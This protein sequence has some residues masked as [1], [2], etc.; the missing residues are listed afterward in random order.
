MTNETTAIAEK[1]R[2][3]ASIEASVLFSQRK[4]INEAADELSRLAALSAAPQAVVKPLEWDAEENGDFI[5][6]SAV[7]WF[8][9][10]RSVSSWN[11]TMPSGK[12]ASFATLDEA[13]AAAQ[14]D[15]EARIL[16]ALTTPPAQAVGV[17]DV[18]AMAIAFLDGFTHGN[19][20]WD[21]MQDH[22]KESYR[23]GIRSMLTASP[24][25]PADADLRA[26]VD[27]LKELNERLY[28]RLHHDEETI[29]GPETR[30]T[31]AEAREKTLR[32]G[33]RDAAVR[34]GVCR[35][36]AEPDGP[37]LLMLLAD[38]AALAAVMKGGEA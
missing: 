10:G 7:G 38:L 36:D 22:H 33:I 8:H 25:P 31:T 9:I 34:A 4:T 28:A 1:L 20:Q 23:E 27:R 15:Y 35:S 14:A 11:L 6:V 30:A 12:V 19:A 26:E 16:S 5:A 2:K 37:Q 29:N 17:P 24:T 32:E 21:H 18:D 3:L 13:K